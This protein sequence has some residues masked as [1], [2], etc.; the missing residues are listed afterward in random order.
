[1]CL[2]EQCVVLGC[3]VSKD[4]EQMTLSDC[5][6]D[7][8]AIHLLDKLIFFNSTVWVGKDFFHPSLLTAAYSVQS[9]WGSW[10]NT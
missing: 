3:A 1:M 4:E 10:A 2:D 5:V 9:Y 8:N 6:L 7:N